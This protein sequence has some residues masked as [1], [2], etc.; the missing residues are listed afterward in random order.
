[1]GPLSVELN[2]QFPKPSGLAHL[3]CSWIEPGQ[4][5][6]INEG[7]VD[8]SHQRIGHRNGI[9]SDSRIVPCDID[10]YNV[11]FRSKAGDL[12]TEVSAAR[13]FQH[14]MSWARQCGAENSRRGLAVG[15]GA[16]E[17]MLI[18]IEIDGSYLIASAAQGNTALEGECGFTH[19]SLYIGEDDHMPLGTRP[20]RDIARNDAGLP[21]LGLDDRAYTTALELRVGVGKQPQAVHLIN[22]A[23]WRPN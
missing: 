20:R 7:V 16:R 21:A 2:D 10:Y 15:Q 5:G 4:H 1:M 17:A 8:R 22:S 18:S 6:K 23:R 14:C 3:H 12:L 9:A 19:A 11:T 13:S